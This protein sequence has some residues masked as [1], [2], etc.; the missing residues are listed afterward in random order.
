MKKILITASLF[1]CG[2]VCSLQSNA[3]VEVVLTCLDEDGNPKTAY[4]VGGCDMINGDEY[5]DYIN[6]LNFIL[7]GEYGNGNQPGENG[8]IVVNP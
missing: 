2:L 4:T 6:E 5:K 8:T 1:L 3:T 7:C